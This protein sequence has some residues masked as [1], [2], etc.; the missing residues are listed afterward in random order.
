M[1]REN[2]IVYLRIPEDLKQRVRE[3]AAANGRSM[4]GEIVFRLRQAYGLASKATAKSV[5]E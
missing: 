3:E 4:T 1:S 5:D 2:P